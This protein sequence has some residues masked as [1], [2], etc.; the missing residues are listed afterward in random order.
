MLNLNWSNNNKQQ[1][2][3]M[4][5]NQTPNKLCLL[6]VQKNEIKWGR[7]RRSRGRR[8]EKT[9][10]SV[11][12]GSLSLIFDIFH[13]HCC[14]YCCRSWRRWWWCFFLFLPPA[15]HAIV[16]AIL[17]QEG[18]NRLIAECFNALMLNAKCLLPIYLPSR[19]K[20]RFI[21]IFPSSSPPHLA[22]GRSRE[23]CLFF[24]ETRYTAQIGENKRKP[25]RKSGA[26]AATATEHLMRSIEQ[27]SGPTREL[28]W[29]VNAAKYKWN[30]WV[31]EREDA[32]TRDYFEESFG[33][34]KIRLWLQFGLNSFM[35]YTLLH[36]IDGAEQTKHKNQYYSTAGCESTEIRI[37]GI[38][39]ARDDAG[40]R[41]SDSI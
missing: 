37:G 23:L 32:E 11:H 39:G 38:Y 1:A 18:S 27:K 20:L 25:C 30:G 31:S 21:F 6:W 8:R 33:R 26:A 14:Y 10:I 15:T 34:H 3:T 17:F 16:Y 19:A 2:I 5:K 36:H 7:R 28:I 24:L 22:L 41:E 29:E 40:D 12:I 9:A 35:P 13:R 4:G